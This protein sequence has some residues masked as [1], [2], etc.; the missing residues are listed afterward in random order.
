MIDLMKSKRSKFMSVL[1]KSSSAFLV[2]WLSSV[3]V[4]V[5]C[6]A[7]LL[8]ASAMKMDEICPMK[9]GHECCAK[10]KDAKKISEPQKDGD[11]CCIFKLNRTLSADLQN[12]KIS[13][14]AATV[15]LSQETPKPVYFIKDSYLAPKVYHSAIRNRG[16]TYLQNCVFRI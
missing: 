5:C 4:L 6:S 10:N 3:L 15:I 1:Q 13:K 12:V 2:I 8:T 11:D 16:S 14:Q 7:H 9:K